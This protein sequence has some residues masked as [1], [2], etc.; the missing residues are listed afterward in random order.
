MDA[1]PLPQE[2]QLAAAPTPLPPPRE[3]LIEAATRLFCRYG[4]NSVGVDAIVD[5]AGTAKTTLYKLFGSKDG[6]VEAVL[7]RE[8]EAWR[9]WFL[10]EI[11]G[12]GGSARERLT[13]IGPTLKIWF[14]RQDYYGCPFINAV[15]ESDK[16][17]DRM[18]TLAIA[19]K[20]VVLERLTQLCAEAGLSEPGMIAHTI[21]L[22][23]DGAIVAALV[24]RDPA[25][26]DAA[27]RGCAA[28]LWTGT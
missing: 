10:Q 28:I 21:G 5:S 8:G 11:D 19:H 24:T 20:R 17:D 26:A 9:T 23:I 12:P 27:G 16:T 22:V 7:Q 13:R 6:L 3:R 2:S 14:S 18:R 4:V 25:V 15:A 1:A